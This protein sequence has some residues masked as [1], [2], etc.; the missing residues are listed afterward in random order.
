MR[1]KRDD[2]AGFTE[3]PDATKD[4]WKQ[5]PAVLGLPVEVDA[6][7]QKSRPWVTWSLCL[8]ILAVGL[9]TMLNLEFWVKEYG[10]VPAQ[11]GRHHGLTF[12][13]SFFLHAGF[14][15]LL[16][17]LY[18]L[19]IFGPKVEEFLGW[20]RYLLVIAGA[21]FAGDLLHITADPKASIPIIGAS[22]GIS[23]VL[24]FYALQ[25]P[26]VRLGLMFRVWF[27][28]RWIEFRAWVWLL[29]WLGLQLIG[30][31]VQLA[32]MSSVSSLAHLGGPCPV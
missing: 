29:I 14:V 4:W 1:E 28:F 13:T 21:A 32:R 8:A 12:L 24:V 11:A 15:H 25:F 30:A 6:P 22:G 18:F 9:V 27:E 19:L 26:R 31:A 20:P 2:P 23:G 17:N 16:T 3:G 10:L 7:E 5:T